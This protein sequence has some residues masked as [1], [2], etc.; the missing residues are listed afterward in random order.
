KIDDQTQLNKELNDFINSGLELVDK[1]QSSDCPLCNHNYDT[2]EK[3][4]ENILSNKLLDS[5]L[6]IY[7]EEKVETE[8][9]INKLV[10]LLSADKENIKKFFSSIKQPYLSDYRNAQNVIDKLGS[11]R[12]INSEKFS[13]NQSILSDIRLSL[14]DS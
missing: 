7:L 3:L 5:Q 9:K 6:K 8:S 14:G 10:L 13:S 12:K 2:F 4:S 1:S 11:E